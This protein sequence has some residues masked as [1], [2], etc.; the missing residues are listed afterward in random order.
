MPLFHRGK[1]S[2]LAEQIGVEEK[3]APKEAFS[4]RPHRCLSVSALSFSLAP[5][6]L[7]L[8]SL[9]LGFPKPPSCSVSS[10]SALS[11]TSPLLQKSLLSAP[12]VSFTETLRASRDPP[13]SQQQQQVSF[14]LPLVFQG[15]RHLKRLCCA[16][17]YQKRENA[18]EARP[19][20]PSSPGSSARLLGSSPPS[21]GPSQLQAHRVTTCCRSSSSGSRDFLFPR[22]SMRPPVDRT[23]GEGLKEVSV[24]TPGDGGREGGG[25]RDG[26]RDGGGDGDSGSPVAVAPSLASPDIVLRLAEQHL[27]R[28]LVV[29]DLLTL[30]TSAL[31]QGALRVQA[32]A[33]GFSSGVSTAAGVLQLVGGVLELLSGIDELIYGLSN[34]E[35]NVALYFLPGRAGAL[36]LHGGAT[37]ATGE[38]QQQKQQQQQGRQQGEGVA[39]GVPAEGR[40]ATGPGDGE[41]E[42]QETT[43]RGDGDLRETRV[44]G[45]CWS[46]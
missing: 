34:G 26:D 22:R 39:R 23:V 7:C 17:P 31:Q 38:P 8:S 20:E 18:R 43:E 6:S 13:V 10:F 32:I 41:V 16:G 1:R 30:Q 21:W 36:P 9:S 44:R 4:Q 5:L 2:V 45:F 37:P 25:D 14:H 40:R 15:R 12:T 19:H 33:G 11:Q 27:A 29:A 24:E 42:G 35:T 46:S 3:A 28:S